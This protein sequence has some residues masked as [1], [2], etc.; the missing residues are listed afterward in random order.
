M[1]IIHHSSS[2][3][4]MRTGRGGLGRFRIRYSKPFFLSFFLFFRFLFFLFFSFLFFYFLVFVSVLVFISFLFLFFLFFPFR[5][6][7]FFFYLFHFFHFFSFLSFFLSFFSFFLWYLGNNNEIVHL[8]FVYF[9]QFF[10]TLSGGL[11]LKSIFAFQY[12]LIIFFGL[13]VDVIYI[14]K[15]KLQNKSLKNL[16]VNYFHYSS[17]LLHHFFYKN[18]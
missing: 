8:S 13:S 9:A 10:L 3:S 18:Q 4:F 12:N 7:F 15:I 6:S 11:P 5:F 1:I 16:K 17:F 14:F 2:S